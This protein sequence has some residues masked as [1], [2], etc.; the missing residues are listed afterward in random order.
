MRQPTRITTCLVAHF[1]GYVIEPPDIQD[2]PQLEK[3]VT[4]WIKN[5]PVY[6]IRHTEYIYPDSSGYV[7][8]VEV[9]YDECYCGGTDGNHTNWCKHRSGC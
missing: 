6:C 8:S 3:D 1:K 7:M 4:N 2:D 9:Y 5:H